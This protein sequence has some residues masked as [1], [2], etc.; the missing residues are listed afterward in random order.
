[1]LLRELI[2]KNNIIQ[3]ILPQGGRKIPNIEKVKIEE[4]KAPPVKI[5]GSDYEEDLNSKPK[6]ESVVNVLTKIEINPT[7][8]YVPRRRNNVNT[9]LIFIIAIAV[10]FVLG[11][12]LLI[13]KYF[14]YVYIDITPKTQAYTLSKES[15][16]TSKEENM[17]LHF[18]IMIVDG[19]DK[20]D[21]V[22]TESKDVST[23]AKGE[24]YIYNEFSTKPQKLLIN[25]KLIDDNQNI[26]LTDKEVSIP[27]YKTSGTKI[28]PGSIAVNVT[29]ALA[30]EK[31]NGEPRDFSI[32]GFKGTTKAT[33][34]YARSN[35][36]LTLGRTGQ[37][38]MLSAQDKGKVIVDSGT[39]L[40]NKLVKKLQAQVPPGYIV[41]TGSMQFSKKISDEVFESKTPEGSVTITGT[42]SAP[43]FKIDE[44]NV[45]LI[46]STYSDVKDE[47]VKEIYSQKM[48]E[49]M[50]AYSDTNTLINKSTT[51]FKFN[52]TGDDTLLWKP[53][54][55]ILRNKI[56]GTN[57]DS[58]DTFYLSDPGIAKARAIFRPPWQSK[59]PEDISHI[60]ISVE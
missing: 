47:E 23:K 38:Y 30:G 49:F 56:I 19:E 10:L 5:T 11:V 46:R 26:Y 12:V 60:K 39:A 17:P 28:I 34:I 13:N 1:M 33:K 24:V 31:Y 7:E 45:A 55:D 18:E 42:L 59:L 15:F 41:Y 29:A 35:G 57:K 14:S 2:M 54:V 25:T 51:N 53:Y 52:L 50:F 27:G 40:Y 21:A 6:I 8:K 58:L 16:T 3:D 4:P 43:I 9:K 22:F 48:K 20:Q 44:L 32:V 37:Y 36:P